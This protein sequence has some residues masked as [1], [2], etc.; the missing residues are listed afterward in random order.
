[1]AMDEAQEKPVRPNATGRLQALAESISR[2]M[3]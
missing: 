1:M 3:R 2:R